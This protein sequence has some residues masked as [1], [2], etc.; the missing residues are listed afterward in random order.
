M[1]LNGNTADISKLFECDSVKTKKG[2]EAVVFSVVDNEKK[3][4]LLHRILNWTGWEFVKG[5]LAKNEDSKKAILREIKEETGITNARIVKKLQEKKEWSAGD[6][7]YEY[8]VFLVETEFTE[9]INLE[10][11]IKEH[12]EFKW[13]SEQEALKLLTYGKSKETL[14][15]LLVDIDG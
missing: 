10:Q 3:F 13:C 2:A 11:E 7:K 5:G 15:E 1:L 14:R 6:M 12:D 4:L 8:D 9:E